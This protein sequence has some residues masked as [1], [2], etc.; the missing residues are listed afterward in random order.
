MSR[1][2]IRKNQKTGISLP[3]T[4]I[5]KERNSKDKSDLK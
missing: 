3:I 1:I 5:E 2:R 4:S